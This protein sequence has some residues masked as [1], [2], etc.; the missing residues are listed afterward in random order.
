MRHTLA[1]M[2]GHYGIDLGI[3]V[4]GMHLDARFGST[5][6]EIEAD[7]HRIVGKIPNVLTDDKA[8]MARAIAAKI[9]GCCDILACERPDIVLL[10]GDRGEM[11]AGAIAAIHNNI[12]VA[13]I[14]GGERSGTIDEPVRHAISRLS[15]LHFPAT[16]EGAERLGRM[17]ERTDCIFDVGAPGLDHL[18]SDASESRIELMSVS[19]WSAN[20]LIAL[21]IFHPVVQTADDGARQIAIILAALRAHNYKI[22]GLRPNSDT[23]G[24]AIRAILDQHSNDP[25][26]QLRTHLPRE[27]FVSWMAAADVMIGNSSAGIIEA[28]S[29]GTPVINV[30]NRQSLRDRNL[31][32]RDVDINEADISAALLDVRR[33]GRFARHNI[34]GDGQTA[35]RITDLLAHLPLPST[36]LDKACVY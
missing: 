10:L 29:F 21:L 8:S 3:I 23:G 15:H 17:G 26:V 7:G 31:N 27:V 6:K 2:R 14:H 34:Y 4:T 18:T 11:L 9:E 30:G 22:V 25:D 16:K 36:L 19:G 20:N 24:E 28:A 35:R 13:H 12:I 33:K 1:A 32:V 5:W